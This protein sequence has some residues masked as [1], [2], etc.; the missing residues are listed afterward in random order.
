MR[1]RQDLRTADLELD[2]ISKC[3]FGTSDGR[4]KK[5]IFTSPELRRMVPQAIRHGS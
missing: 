2:R 4:L 3:G 5:K 1:V